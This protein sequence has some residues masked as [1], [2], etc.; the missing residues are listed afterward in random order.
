MRTI[1]EVI[2]M[3]ENRKEWHW[4]KECHWEIDIDGTPICRL[5]VLPCERVTQNFCEKKEDI[6][7][8][9]T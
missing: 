7:D 3:P 2:E 1:W 5:N 9:K 4:K 6:N 8:C